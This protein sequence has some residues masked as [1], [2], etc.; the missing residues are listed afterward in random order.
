MAQQQ[1][2][3]APAN[4]TTYMQGIAVP[5]TSVRPQEFFARTRRNIQ[6]EATRTY[7]PNKTQDVIELRKSGILST[8]TV[9]FSGALTV[10]PG[11]GSVASTARWP[12]D[13]ITTRFTANSQANIINVSGSKLK[14]REM[15][16]RT[17]L[18]DRGVTRTVGA[19][20]VNQGT[21]SL[22]SENWGVGSG[23]SSLSAGTYPVELHWVIPVSEDEVD[24]AGAIFMATSTTD[25]TLALDYKPLTALFTTTGNGAVALSGNFTVQ[26][27]KFSIPLGGDGQIV[28]PDLSMF[29]TLIQ[30]NTSAIQ[31]GD[32]EVRIVGQGAGKSM[33]RTYYQLWNGAANAAAPLP[34][35]ASNFGAQSWRY[36]TNET[37]D[38]FPN[39]NIMRIQNERQFC[40]DLGGVFGYLV[41]DFASDLEF[42]DV[43]DMGTTGDLRLAVNVPS[44]VTL[45]QPSLEY[46]VES[47]F[48]GGAA[49]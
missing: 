46:V 22:A 45:T 17:Q 30:S 16:K 9:T 49:V 47:V 2:P 7:D 13:L 14:A 28:V 43:V 1:A 8:I 15:M 26:A 48:H 6:Q 29:H 23:T 12:Y 42:R 11:T 4:S 25:I 31:N 5:S 21:L 36:G 18:N 38:T 33:L 44:A 32:N 40:S 37:P 10:T 3:A 34:A 41:H 20:T 39:G 35:T 24:L 19:T 27:T